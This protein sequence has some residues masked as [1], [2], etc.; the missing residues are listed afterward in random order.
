MTRITNQPPR[1]MVGAT[2]DE[3]GV[4]GYV[5]TPTAGTAGSHLTEFLRK[6]GNYAVPAGGGGGGSGVANSYN[7]SA[8]STGNTTITVAANIGTHSERT[9]LTGLTSTTRVFILSRA[10]VSAGAIIR[11]R[12]VAPATDDITIEWRDNAS[13]GTLLTDAITDASGDDMIAEFVYTGSA[14]ILWAFIYPANA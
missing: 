14:W 10:N 11:H 2:A 1:I 6:D 12:V 5:P 8:N 13:N 4:S 7:A 3:D 9:T